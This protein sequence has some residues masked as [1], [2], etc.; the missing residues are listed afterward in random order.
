MHYICPKCKGSLA[1]ESS[2]AVCQNGHSFDRARQGYYNLLLGNGGGVHGDN[3][4]MV[5]ARRSFLNGGFYSPL[6]DRVSYLVLENTPPLGR[7]LDA[8]CGEGYYT[9]VVEEALFSRDGDTNVLAF[10]ISRDAVRYALR[11]CSRLHCAVASSYDMP[12]ADTSIDMVVNVFSPLAIDEV[13]RVLKRGGHFIMV[14]PAEEHLFSLKAAIYDT[15]YKNKHEDTEI[16]GFSLDHIENLEYDISLDKSEDIKN[17]FMMTP[18]AY[19]TSEKGRAR[20]SSL[21]SLKTKASFIIALYTK[22]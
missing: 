4:D 2:R 18:Y 16:P 13:R 10:D 11:R 3:R 5:E 20:L 12:I 22:I 14:Y 1:E 7:V 15:P 6:A 17:L 21:E 8:G 19:R 9:S